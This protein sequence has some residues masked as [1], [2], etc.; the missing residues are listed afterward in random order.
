MTPRAVTAFVFCRYHK[1]ASSFVRFPPSTQGNRLKP[2]EGAGPGLRG[3]SARALSN[4]ARMVHAMLPGP[5]PAADDARH[6]GRG[7]GWRVRWR[8][9]AGMTL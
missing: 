9:W 6:R 4:C 5:F 2:V 8:R 1:A 3:S 7:L